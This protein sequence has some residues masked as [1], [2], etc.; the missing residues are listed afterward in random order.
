MNSL[1]NIENFFFYNGDAHLIL[2]AFIKQNERRA[3]QQYGNRR[4]SRMDIP[5]IS[6]FDTDTIKDQLIDLMSKLGWQ[7]IEIRLQNLSSDR[8]NIVSI[9]ANR[10]VLRQNNFVF[11]VEIWDEVLASVLSEIELVENPIDLFSAFDDDIIDET[12]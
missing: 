10:A 6:I 3:R 7:Q 9:A 11:P 2:D 5:E 1:K 4:A 8:N 12:T